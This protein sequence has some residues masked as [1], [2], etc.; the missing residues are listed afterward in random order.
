[1]FLS[2]RPGGLIDAPSGNT[3]A[4]DEVE[5]RIQLR[6]GAFVRRGLQHG[7]RVILHYDNRRE[8]FVDL[9]ALW[10]LGICAV[11][12]DPRLTPYALAHVAAAVAPAATL[13]SESSDVAARSALQSLDVTH[14]EPDDATP[15][16]STADSYAPLQL[17]DAALILFTSGTTAAAKGVV[18][19]HR[20]LCARW[21]VQR[22]I[23]GVAPFA[24][25]LCAVPVNFAWGLVGNALY[26]W[27]SGQ[28]LVIAPAFRNDVVLQLGTLCD[29]FAVT[30]LP[31]VPTL[32]KTALK[33]ARPPRRGTLLRASSGTAALTAPLWTNIGE[34]TGTRDVLN[35]Y[36]ITETGWIA[37]ASSANLAAADGLVGQGWGCTISILQGNDTGNGAPW[38]LRPCAPGE[39]GHVWVQSASLMAGYFGRTEDTRRITAAGWLCTG[40]LGSLDPATGALRL[41]GRDKDMINV[42]GVKVYP[43]DVDAVL[44]EHQDVADVC[45]FAVD[46]FFQGESVA[47]AIVLSKAG[48]ETKLA[49]VV[50]WAQ[51]RLARHQVPRRWY[52]V[53]DIARSP[54]GKLIRSDIARACADREPVNLVR[55]ESPRRTQASA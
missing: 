50:D 13:W 9:L 55:L 6:M 38:S 15:R 33:M 45:T 19:T 36:G 8:F 16:H 43:E 29:E 10:R 23:L 32:W 39:V 12:V 44:S 21:H 46:D 24:R 30:Y 20:S 51:D 41:S 37:G 4:Q 28:T 7:Q 34:W 5:R 25:T 35:I 42:G 27:L 47:V 18:H 2:L 1:M 22:E 48:T 49:A 40:D 54:R 3:W 53:A 17:D 52:L 14:I 11:P 26:A 31:L